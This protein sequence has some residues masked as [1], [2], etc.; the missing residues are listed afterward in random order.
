VLSAQPRLLSEPVLRAWAERLR[1]AVAPRRGELVLDSPCAGGVLSGVLARR[2]TVRLIACDTSADELAVATGEVAAITSDRRPSLIR[3][4][5][6]SLPLGDAVVDACVSLFSLP[7]VP[8]APQALR[9]LVRVLHPRGRLVCAAWGDLSRTPHEAALAAAF[10]A[11]LGRRSDFVERSLSLGTQGAPERLIDAAG[12]QSRLRAVR[13]RDVVRFDGISHYWQAMVAARP[14]ARELNGESPDTR[15][16]LRADC[17]Q[18]LR[19]W[20]AADGTMRIPAEV[21]LLLAG[22]DVAP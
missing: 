5:S 11:V 21:V 19:S 8:S 17:E 16:A 22:V 4:D 2:S 13:V 15:A 3:A 20:P 12:V 7:L 6:R 9:E 14:V 10:A 18:R 1:A